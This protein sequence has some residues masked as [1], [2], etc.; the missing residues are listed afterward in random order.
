MSCVLKRSMIIHL[1]LS[2]SQDYNTQTFS[3]AQTI[4]AHLPPALLTDNSLKI[5]A[6]IPFNNNIPDRSWQFR[7]PLGAQHSGSVSNYITV[8]AHTPSIDR[9]KQLPKIHVHFCTEVRKNEILTKRFTPRPVHVRCVVD[10]DTGLCFSVS[11]YVFSCHYHATAVSIFICHQGGGQSPLSQ[12]PRD[13]FSHHH[14]NNNNTYR[15]TIYCCNQSN[16]R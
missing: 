11:C 9:V 4:T 2:L 6:T 10:S 5:A 7:P 15:E 16:L 14:N 12:V 3:P 1:Y 8:A 13:I